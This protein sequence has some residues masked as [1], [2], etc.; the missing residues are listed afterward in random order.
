MKKVMKTEGEKFEEEDRGRPVCV[1]SQ[2]RGVGRGVCGKC[3]PTELSFCGKQTQKQTPPRII[4]E[5]MKS[6]SFEKAR[7]K[8]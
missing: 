5:M 8:I 3:Y 2:N 7:N 6:V 1:K 4:S